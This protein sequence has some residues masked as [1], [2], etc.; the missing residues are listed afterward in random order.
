MPSFNL[1]SGAEKYL[2]QCMDLHVLAFAG[3]YIQKTFN[4]SII[5]S[6]CSKLHTLVFG[7]Q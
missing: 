3:I 5:F 2:G 7:K 4:F 1:N 6:K